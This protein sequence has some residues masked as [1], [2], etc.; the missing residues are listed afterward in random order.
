MVFVL[1]ATY[2]YGSP[3]AKKPAST[4]EPSTEYPLPN[5]SEGADETAPALEHKS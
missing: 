3:D 5:L 1:Y 2:L 4:G